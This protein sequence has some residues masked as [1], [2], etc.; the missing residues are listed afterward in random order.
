M[1]NTVPLVSILCLTYNQKEYIRQ[2][3][4]SFLAQ[5]TDFSYEVLIN[6][7]ASTDGTQKILKEYAKRYP[8]I[9]P[10][11]QK[12]NQY[13]KGKRN[14]MIRYLLPK[15]KGKYIALCEG[16]DFWTDPT[17]LQRQVDFLESHK[18]YALVF[19]PVRVFFE[20][21][22]EAD[23]IFP[24]QK[25]G[26][27]VEHLLQTNFIQTNSV[28]YRAQKDYSKIPL[29]VMPGDWYL[30]L[31]HAQYGK[32]GFIDRV[33]SAYRRHEGGIW[34]D[35]ATNIEVFWRKYGYQHLRLYSALKNFYKGEKQH[36]IIDKNINTAIIRL[37]EHSKDNLLTDEVVREYQN[38][39]ASVIA[40]FAQKT[41]N[42]ARD[43]SRQQG[44]LDTI[45]SENEYLRAEVTK[46]NETIQELQSARAYRYTQR[47][48]T[49]LNKLK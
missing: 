48:K 22:Q 15:A 49:I 12:E 13:S 32:I 9:R 17:K 45:M 29:D 24:E 36:E 34:W 23:T 2:T 25:S 20:N 30:H 47:I 7:D 39:L 21:G 38:N 31:F 19:H 35:S 44:Q 1:K 42:L 4:D 33:M 5:E 26:F 11:L 14:M 37:A 46:L 3:I 18:D 8:N 16:D 6:D 43:I 40:Y 10:V 28:M 41:E 27:N